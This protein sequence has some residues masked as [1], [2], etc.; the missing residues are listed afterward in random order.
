MGYRRE[1]NDVVITA[2]QARKELAAW[3]GMRDDIPVCPACHNML[4]HTGDHAWGAASSGTWD[5]MGSHAT[6]NFRW[7]M[8]RTIKHG[9]TFAGEV[10]GHLKYGA[11]KFHY[12]MAQRQED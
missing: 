7:T 4:G 8:N 1:A 11:A 9:H 10:P 6:N 5:T 3:D 12:E 2:D